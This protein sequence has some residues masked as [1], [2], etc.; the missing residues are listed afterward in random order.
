M[1]HRLKRRGKDLAVLSNADRVLGIVGGKLRMQ[2]DLGELPMPLDRVQ[3]IYFGNSKNPPSRPAPG[4]VRLK[5]K[6]D[7]EVAGVEGRRGEG[8]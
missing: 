5:L 1:R 8:E 2:S 3:A 6:D 7:G 4:T